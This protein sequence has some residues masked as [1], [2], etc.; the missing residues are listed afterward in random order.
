M[1]NLIFLVA[2]TPAEH[3]LGT[4]YIDNKRD[5]STKSYNYAIASLKANRY[6]V[7]DNNY[8]ID[9]VDIPVSRRM[10]SLPKKIIS[11][12]TE[13]NPY[14]VG[15]STYCWDLH[16]FLK[17]AYIIKEYNSE[18]KI[19]MGGPSV[20]FYPEEILNKY[21]QV[22]III[23]GEG[24]YVFSDLLYHKFKNLD[25]VAGV[26]Y[27]RKDNICSNK[28]VKQIDLNRIY[29][30]YLSDNFRPKSDTLMIEPSRGCIYRCKFCSWSKNKKL[31]FK[32]SKI[33][34]D[35]LIWAYK[36]GY[37]F[38]NLSDTSINMTEEQLST[39]IRAIKDSSVSDKLSFSVFMK[40]DKINEAQL[41]IIEDIRFDE[42]IFGL[43]SINSEALLA[44]GKPPFNKEKFE[45]AIKK[46]GER[47]NKITLS[48]MIGLPYDTFN[49][50]QKTI[51]YTEYLLERYNRYINFVCS[52]WLA[53]LPGTRFE[54]EKKIHKFKFLQRGTPYLIESK[55][56]TP[57]DLLKTAEL[58]YKE[59]QT[60]TKFFCEEYFLEVLG[61]RI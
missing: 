61:Q 32:S 16:I 44:S 15:F 39:I 53:V 40:Y 25:E 58:I 26:V 17:T 28:N 5:F 35:E 11:E 23:P 29:S 33:L 9:L 7:G 55:Y 2:G 27:R 43:E 22:D 52:F 19:I 18:I 30:P 41:K 20:S 1:N 46:L 24:E 12:I 56:M 48:I 49:S 54:R 45:T 59:T 57:K 21:P 42:I 3:S 34:T 60:N 51:R 37:R 36:N 47:G 38:I 13:K 10:N 4:E 14:A 6:I 8:N 50:I 31:M